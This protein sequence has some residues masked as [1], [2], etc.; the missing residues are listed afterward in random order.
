MDDVADA[1]FLTLAVSLHAQ[2]APLFHFEPKP[3][4]YGVGLKVV[5]QYDHIRV[6]RSLP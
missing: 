3:G 6:Y 2:T 4:P 1:C 5:E